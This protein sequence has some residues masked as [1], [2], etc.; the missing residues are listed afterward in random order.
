MVML[1]EAGVSKESL[2]FGGLSSSSGA[3]RQRT[4]PLGHFVGAMNNS[5]GTTTPNLQ[6][7]ASR[8]AVDEVTLAA[9]LNSQV[10]FEDQ[11]EHNVK[12]SGPLADGT[13]LSSDEVERQKMQGSVRQSAGP[14]SKKSRAR[15]SSIVSKLDSEI[16]RGV[17]FSLGNS[18][19][20]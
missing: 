10:L 17:Y 8:V 20:K 4:A 16:S 13:K 9:Q 19:E 14:S 18:T 15:R 2:N 3:A 5:S 11:G 7:Q 12:G 1:D 6:L